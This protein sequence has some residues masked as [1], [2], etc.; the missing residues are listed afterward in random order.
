MTE[1]NRDGPLMPAI[2]YLET[3]VIWGLALLLTLGSGILLLV[4]HM[5][6]SILGSFWVGAAVMLLLYTVPRLRGWQ[7]EGKRLRDD[8]RKMK[9]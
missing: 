1:P 6:Q 2:R 4:W 3:G 7:L 9:R 5:T 8:L